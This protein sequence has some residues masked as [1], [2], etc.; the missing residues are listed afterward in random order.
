MGLRGPLGTP[1]AL[2]AVRGN[3]GHRKAEGKTPPAP[4]KPSGFDRQVARD[5]RTVYRRLMRWHRLYSRLTD[6]AH[7][8]LTKAA[9]PAERQA[10]ALLLPP[11]SLEVAVKAAKEALTVAYRSG[12]VGN[13]GEEARDT[14]EE[15]RRSKRRA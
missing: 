8:A 7:R 13:D 14:F 2:Q 12:K 11:K 3:P 9:T 1:P 4:P 6:E 5:T 15:F 10:A